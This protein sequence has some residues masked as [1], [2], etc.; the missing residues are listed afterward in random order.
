MAVVL[1]GAMAA[2]ST[3]F[4]GP[5]D[6][7]ST[8]AYLKAL[9]QLDDSY[10]AL[11]PQARSAGERF[12]SQVNAECPGALRNV[13]AG[14]DQTTSSMRAFGEQA[15]RQE[16]L[17]LLKE[18]LSSAGQDA[19]FETD[20]PAFLTFE[21]AVASLPWEDAALKAAIANELQEA[22]ARL[23][24]TA[25][26]ICKD[27]EAWVASGYRLLP[28]GTKV[29]LAA[30][31][32]QERHT[33]AERTIAIGPALKH[34]ET[35]EGRSLTEAITHLTQRYLTG[36]QSA[37]ETLEGAREAIGLKSESRSEGRALER[38]IEHTT[39]LG[40]GRTATGTWFLVDV[41]K[42]SGRCRFEI[43]VE[44]SDEGS[45]GG[46][47]LCVTHARTTVAR[48]RCEEEERVVNAVMPASVHS[49]V[50]HLA[51][52]RAL[53]SKT[54]ALP[55]HLGGPA[56]FYHQAVP[57]G[58][59]VP[60]SMTE[61]GAYGRRLASVSLPVASKCIRYGLHSV[62]GGSH[63]LA[64]GLIPGGPAFT[65]HGNAFAYNGPASL[66]LSVELAGQGG[67]GSG[68]S[69]SRPEVL[70]MTTYDGCYPVDF[71][72]V[73]GVLKAAGDTVQARAG[74]ELTTLRRVRFPASLR[75]RGVLVYGVF[76]G[77]IESIVVRA[78]GGREVVS[79]GLSR[80]TNEQR[81]YCEGFIE[82][83]REPREEGQLLHAEN[84]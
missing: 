68:L 31:E 59:H 15:L 42:T 71:H 12:T 18:E 6:V 25:P 41:V 53:R 78:P 27:V 37:Y 54:F 64:R 84:Q 13:E 24:A 61:L 21:G 77:P 14:L 36:L 16:Q 10:L 73:Y 76:V 80:W 75:T 17:S 70:R 50:L 55:A 66:S 48:V 83:G 22:H 35:N 52:G 4:A 2:P 32:A 26:A 49:V 20:Q 44:G 33:R 63:V 72:I 11:W 40:S 51:G 79:E 56:A 1:I 81:E 74:G 30:Q 7:A 82:P 47:P 62:S 46:K 45:S 58:P 38:E 29:F 39:Q 69:G 19:L 28:A 60:L 65:I 8:Q 9:Y 23:F 34:F 3:S 57:R 5:Q 43:K 67:G